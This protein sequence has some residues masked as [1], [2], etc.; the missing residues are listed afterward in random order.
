[1]LPKD[2][3]DFRERVRRETV[4]GQTTYFHENIEQYIFRQAKAYTTLRVFAHWAV[5]YVASV[6]CCQVMLYTFP[7]LLNYSSILKHPNYV[8]LGHFWS[9]FYIL[10]A[11]LCIK[12]LY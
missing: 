11:P 6:H 7:N 12:Y 9:W 1:M 10:R 3:S 4:R 5:I 2:R 8:K